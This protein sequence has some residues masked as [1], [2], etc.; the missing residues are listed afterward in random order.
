MS[1]VFGTFTMLVENYYHC[2]IYD[3]KVKDSLIFL[4]SKRLVE[5]NDFTPPFT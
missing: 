4:K 1:Q 5:V 3:I 2:V